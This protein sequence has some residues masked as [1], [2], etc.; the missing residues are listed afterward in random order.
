VV[1]V[2]LATA[3]GG[4]AAEIDSPEVGPDDRRTCQE[5]LDSLPDTL[6]SQPQRDVEPADALGAAW[7]DP[8]ITLTCGV[9]LP[10]EYDEF[11]SCEEANGVG[12][13]L[14]PE[15][16]EDQGLDVT[17]TAVG[18][19]P[20]VQVRVPSSYRPEGPASVIVELGPVVQDQLELVQ[21]CR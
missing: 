7:G 5:L 17:F 1:L 13:F 20:L 6:A 10:A 15:Q 4:G 18:Y 16:I 11:S 19:R 2:Y 9:A 14:P 12:W 8:A 3:C 21:D